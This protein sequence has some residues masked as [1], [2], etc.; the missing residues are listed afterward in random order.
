MVRLT[1]PTHNIPHVWSDKRCKNPNKRKCGVCGGTMGFFSTYEKCRSCKICVHTECKA[2]VQDNCGLTSKHFKEILTHMVISAR[3]DNWASPNIGTSKSLNDMPVIQYNDSQTPTV[4][5]SSSS[6][7]SSAPST[8]AFINQVGPVP[9]IAV[10]PPPPSS[11]YDRLTAPPRTADLP[12]RSKQFTFPDVA[13]SSGNESDSAH[14]T[15]S[16]GTINFGGHKW[17]RRAWNMFTIR[18]GSMSWKD[19]TIPMKDIK[20]N[21]IIGSGRFGDVYDVEHFG[22]V[23]IKFPRMDHVDLD[24]RIEAFK[25]ETAC[26]QNARHENLIFFVGYTMDV[27]MLGVVT[28]RIR[29]PSLY[30]VIHEE[31]LSYRIDFNDVIDYAKQICQGMSYLHTK[32]IAHK[33]LRT[34]NIFIENRKAVITDFGLFNVKRLA[35]PKCTHGFLVPKHWISYQA[36]EVLRALTQDLDP[37][38]FNERTDVYSFGTVWYELIARKFPFNNVHSDSVFWQICKEGKAPIGKVNV[39]REAKVLLMHCWAMRP[40]DRKLFVDLLESLELMPRK[41]LRRSPSFPV[42]KS[43]ESIF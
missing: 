11:A 34:K 6:T 30:K 14:S 18:H 43:F 35:Y 5:D 16:N 27:S 22:T 40:L 31:S 13:N 9:T 15:T 25:Q 29:G 17:D 39:C 8:P 36:P 1:M 23:A 3:Q 28:E 41:A 24:K 7:N 10:H 32:N 12:S 37:I 20:I 21:K 38:Y 42:C 33:D 4:A 2:R 19:V 26:F